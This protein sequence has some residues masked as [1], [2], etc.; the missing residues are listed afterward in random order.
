MMISTLTR[1]SVAAAVEEKQLG[2]LFLDL[3]ARHAAF[4]NEFTSA[5]RKVIETSA[6]AGGPF[7]KRFE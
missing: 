2:V 7:V 3:N 6:F 5:I 1:F 4:L